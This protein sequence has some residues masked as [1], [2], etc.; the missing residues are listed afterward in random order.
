LPLT[1]LLGRRI[2]EPEFWM[3]VLGAAGY[4]VTQL[5]SRLRH[6]RHARHSGRPLPV[7]IAGAA[8]FALLTNSWWTVGIAAIDLAV[9]A[10]TSV[11]RHRL[12]RLT[13][14]K[15]HSIIDE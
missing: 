3:A 1:T 12:S 13:G 14:P 5:V 10:T 8:G 4:A 15:R 9:I 6:R 2:L 11:V 7:R